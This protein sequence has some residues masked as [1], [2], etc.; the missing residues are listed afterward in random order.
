[1]VNV[2]VIVAHRTKLNNFDIAALRVGLALFHFE[3]LLFVNSKSLKNLE[4]VVK[5][6][7]IKVLLGFLKSSVKYCGRLF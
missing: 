1:M 5:I 2:L 3:V 7:E 4:K 6:K